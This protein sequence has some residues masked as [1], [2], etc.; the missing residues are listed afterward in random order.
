MM[1]IEP[2]NITGTTL[3]EQVSQIKAYLWKLSEALNLALEE[4][5]RQNRA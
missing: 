5:N 3:P 1:P 2:P 4:R